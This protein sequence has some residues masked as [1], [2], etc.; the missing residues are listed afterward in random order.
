M[1]D[2]RGYV[3]RYS[4]DQTGRL[5][6]MTDPLG[7]VT[8]YEYDANNNLTTLIEPLGQRTEM[9]YDAMNRLKTM[10]DAAGSRTEYCYDA[11]DRL[12]RVIDPRGGIT[13]YAYDEVDNLIEIVDPLDAVTRSEYDP[14]D[15]RLALIDGN[16]YRTDFTYDAI[17]R[18]RSIVR[19]PVT[20]PGLPAPQRPTTQ[21]AYDGVG[22]TRVITS[23]R[24][25]ATTFSYD[26]NDNLRTLT[27][28]LGGQT[29][30]TYDEED[31][32]VTVTDPNN[33][34]TTISYNPVDLPSQVQDP[35]G[36]TTR[37]DYDAGYNLNRL[38]NALGRPTLYNYDPQ[39]QV[40]RVTDPLGN[41]T[42]YERDLQGRVTAM[43]DA[44]EHTTR[45]SYDPLGR[46]MG[47]TDA[48]NGLTHY[49]YDAAGNLVAMNDA[50]NHI[51]RFAYDLRNQLTQEINSLGKTW[52]YGYDAAG[53]LV[54]RV[55]GNGHATQYSY[56]SNNRLVGLDY[57]DAAKVRFGYDLDGN[58][59]EMCDWLAGEGDCALTAYDPLNRPTDSAD[60]L[61]RTLKR[62]YDA[63]GNL[64]Q[65]I[66]PN[67]QPLKY[68]YDA[69][70]QL[71]SLED[72]FNQRTLYAYDPLGLLTQVTRPNSTTTAYAYD[73]A[74]RL[75]RLLHQRE[76]ETFSAFA[77]ALDKV[78]NRTQ[79]TELRTFPGDGTPI[80]VTTVKHYSYD[81]LNR[82]LDADTDQGQDMAYNFDPVG[83]RLK[84]AGIP[85]KIDPTDDVEPVRPGPPITDGY[86]Y[87]EANQ[88]TAVSGQQSAVALAYDGNGNRIRETEV[89]EGKTWL[90][91]YRYDFENRLVGVTKSVQE[92]AKLKVTMVAT[93]TYDGYG[94]RV[95]KEISNL[96]SPRQTLTYLYN[97]LDPIADYETI[98]R[99]TTATHYYWANG[100][101]A[102]I[103]RQP[104]PKAGFAGDR[105]WT[106]TDGLGSLIDLTNAKGRPMMQVYYDEYGQLL[107]K[108][109][110]LTRYSFTG[111]E[112]DAETELY[113]FYAR[114]YDPVTGFWLS[115]D[116]YRGWPF[117][118]VS[119]HRYQY[120]MNE[121]VTFIDWY[122]F[123]GVNIGLEGRGSLATGG[124]GDLSLEAEFSSWNPNDWKFSIPI[125][126]FLGAETAAGFEGDLDFSIWDRTET[127]SPLPAT[128]HVGGQGSFVVSGKAGYFNGEGKEG[129][130]FTLGGGSKVGFGGYAYAS[131]QLAELAGIDNQS[132]RLGCLG[133][134]NGLIDKLCL[135]NHQW[136]DQSKQILPCQVGYTCSEYEPLSCVEYSC[137]EYIPLP[138]SS[139]PEQRKLPHQLLT[140]AEVLQPGISVDVLAPVANIND[141]ESVAPAD[142]LSLPDYSNATIQVVDSPTQDWEIVIK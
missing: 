69:R 138:L 43:T 7:A 74:D 92:T 39:G 11:E 55:D 106:H 51:T 114:Y 33:H 86:T 58:Q 2:R 32:P 87:N 10:I 57:P 72:H 49:E 71:I 42:L 68:A 26:E 60:W 6:T 109:R 90:T 70:N 14:V 35:L 34:T 100:G 62:S 56:D 103:E 19:P 81:A 113:H 59:I 15:N 24:N 117:W 78:G 105:Y 80:P 76:G 67:G 16:N 129:L 82:L 61:G 119:L 140:P 123:F 128:I 102:E 130:E 21:F 122:G 120:L 79:I 25:F 127:A 46:L 64:I 75:T 29:I 23:P 52:G 108:A 97:G 54:R 44:N 142:I 124:G 107:T 36:H 22:N 4:Y 95:R 96:Q 48:L 118:P 8:R 50:N 135:L 20:G 27:D 91:E 125:D 88:L 18:L 98:G 41:V 110:S 65:L 136:E 31:N 116:I 101:I 13:H 40:V 85:Q 77:Y 47:V 28:P 30:Y 121:P 3:T 115:Q 131:T 73:E 104:N 45:Y 83:N 17:N 9:V 132:I 99:V 89:R 38:I 141:I 93:Y 53:N 111:Q 139:G 5:E 37:F 126:L 112:F 137:K 84:Q 1:T 12:I 94:R 133:D 63:A 66:Y 134:L